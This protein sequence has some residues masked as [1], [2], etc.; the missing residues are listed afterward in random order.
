[1]RI[2]YKAFIEDHFAILD[3]DS[4]RPVP[5]KLNPIQERYLEVLREE[6][7]DMEGIREIV[8]KARQEGMSSFILALFTV[9]FICIPHSISIC[10]SHRKDATEL[11]FRKVKFYLESYCA[12]TGQDPK[13]YLGT[14]SKTLIQ[15]KKRN[16]MFYILT[17]G[18]GVGGRGG[19]ARNILFSEAAFYL[20]SEK[21]RA[22]EMINA[23]S[24]QVPQGKGMVFIESTAN[25]M[26]NFYQQEWERSSLH[27]S[28]YHPRFFAAKDFYSEEWLAEKKKEFRTQEQFK[29]EYPDNPDEA[30][31]ASGSPYFDNALLKKLLDSRPPMIM[32]GHIASD[33]QWV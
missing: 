30:F 18:S 14:D 24:Q 3:K 12:K 17:A 16:S 8:L 4:Q 6:H 5:F 21:I 10:I 1:M 15:S 25:G 32:Q 7:P 22:D 26:D 20:D 9:D 28:A 19:S 29:Q 27:R 31:I 13:E 23:T 2:D 11:L 33:G